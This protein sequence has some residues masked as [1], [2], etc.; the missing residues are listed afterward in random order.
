MKQWHLLIIMPLL[1]VSIL[2][3]LKWLIRPA[4]PFYHIWLRLPVKIV[5]ARVL[6]L[7]S[8]G[9]DEV[10]CYDWQGRKGWL[11]KWEQE[12]F[13]LTPLQ[14]FPLIGGV[15]LAGTMS[16]AIW[17]GRY[18]IGKTSLKDIAVAEHQP[19]GQWRVTT[20]AKDA[21]S[22]G[23][24]DFDGD[25]QPNDAFLLVGQTAQRGKLVWFQQRKDRC[26]HK[27]AELTLSIPPRLSVKPFLLI[28]HS[29]VLIP[30]YQPA[31]L[32]KARQ[33]IIMHQVVFLQKQWRLSDKGSVFL[34][35]WDGDGEQDALRFLWQPQQHRLSLELR[36]SKWQRT[37]KQ[38]K[39]FRHWRLVGQAS[40]NE[41]GDGIQHLLLAFHDGQRTHLVDGVFA[42]SGWRWDKLATFDVPT[43]GQD[44][45]FMFHIGD[46]DGDDDN[47]LVA[48]LML[49]KRGTLLPSLPHPVHHLWLLR[50]D[51]KVWSVQPIQVQP[52]EAVQCK[53][54]GKRFW[55]VKEVITQRTSGPKWHYIFPHMVTEVTT[56]LFTFRPDGKSQIIAQAPG[57][58]KA[59]D[60]LNKDGF[61][62][63]ITRQP[64]GVEPFEPAWFWFR[65]SGQKWQGFEV[66]VRIK[67]RRLMEGIWAEMTNSMQIGRYFNYATT[68]QW[69]GKKWFL[70]VWNDGLLQAVT[71]PR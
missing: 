17:K 15:P 56:Q 18:A 33:V 47:D 19:N 59:I 16:E 68:V 40:T 1:V 30:C 7:D 49:V 20:L 58:L 67:F 55:F 53:R 46:A 54:F 64:F 38:M 13:R 5:N 25:G 6:D 62:E 48:Q 71:A 23:I 24:G 63:F 27:V 12:H 44:D 37:F 14:P 21:I 10:V 39:Q 29:R 42:P 36:S 51:R 28:E 70:L 60:D 2:L 52:N 57:E 4:E 69:G 35:D 65:S 8:D 22:Y 26:W 31:L 11:L 34:G 45:H 50:R 3:A 66:P 41:L 9:S 32:P 61:P 43:L